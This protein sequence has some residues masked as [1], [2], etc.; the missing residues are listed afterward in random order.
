MSF[1]QISHIAKAIYA[2]RTRITG[3]VIKLLK[4]QRGDGRIKEKMKGG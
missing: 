3:N 1:H 2:K 4:Q